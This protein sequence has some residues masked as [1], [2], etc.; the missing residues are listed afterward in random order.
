MIGEGKGYPF[1]YSGLE[2][3]MDYSWGGG[4]V[5]KSRIQLRDFHLLTYRSVMASVHEGTSYLQG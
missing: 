4:R 2:N 1:Q 5:T 3:S